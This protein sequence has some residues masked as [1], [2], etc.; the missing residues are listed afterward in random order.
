MAYYFHF[1]LPQGKSGVARVYVNSDGSD[2][3]QVMHE[4][5][6]YPR[7]NVHLAEWFGVYPGKPWE[8]ATFDVDDAVEYCRHANRRWQE[9][10]KQLAAKSVGKA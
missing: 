10:A 7:N 8:V 2:K 3:L 9:E 4:K 1:E 6:M 5:I